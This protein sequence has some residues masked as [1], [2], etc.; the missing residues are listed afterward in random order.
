M[1]V[2]T[3]SAPVGHSAAH[4]NPS[5][6]MHA[7]SI[8]SMYGVPAHHGSLSPTNRIT[9][10]ERLI[11]IRTPRRKFYRHPAGPAQRKKNST[12]PTAPG[13]PGI[14]RARL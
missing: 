2:G 7:D 4:G 12:V 14:F 10:F 1:V 9:F 6:S 8:G 11:F 13:G 3:S 5:H